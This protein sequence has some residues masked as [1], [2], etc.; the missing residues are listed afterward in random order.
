[1]QRYPVRTSHRGNLDLADLT[2]MLSAHFENVDHDGQAVT[3]R[4]GAIASIKV[5][6][7]GRELA[8]EVRMDPKVAAEVAQA[9]V[10]RYNRF[11]EETTGY[12]AKERARR[13]RKSATGAAP[14]A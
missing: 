7:E 10:Q 9:T 8:V 14:G 6:A 4:F 2:R 3:A 11:L 13:L 12:T 5:W 1:V